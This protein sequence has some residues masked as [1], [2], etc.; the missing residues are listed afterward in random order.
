MTQQLYATS[1]QESTQGEQLAKANPSVVIS[2]FSS[3]VVQDKGSQTLQT[4]LDKEYNSDLLGD[5]VIYNRSLS[6]S[7]ISSESS[8]SIFSD[9][10]DVADLTD[11]PIK[12]KPKVSTI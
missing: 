3:R 6:S 11:F 10:S 4:D 9:S 7:S 8:L 12:L 2:D 1:L 5:R